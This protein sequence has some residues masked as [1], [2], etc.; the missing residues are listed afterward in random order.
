M[1]TPGL[2]WE[3]NQ[4]IRQISAVAFLFLFTA[5]SVLGSPIISIGTYYVSNTDTDYRIPIMVSTTS[6]ERVEGVNLA[7]QIADGGTPNGG[8]AT[9]PTIKDLDIVGTGTIFNASNTGCTPLYQGVGTENE[10]PY[11]LAMASTTVESGSLEANGIL[12]YLTI[13][14]SGAALGSY[15]LSLQE[16]G[17]N[18]DGGPWSTDFCGISAAIMDDGWIVVVPE[19]SVLMLLSVAIVVL[20]IGRRLR[21]SI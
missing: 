6:N 9:S 5:S 14:A 12:A 13:D 4:M 16:I 10:A 8:T 20:F 1:E 15:K 3:Y 21:N 18:L 19:P 11:L 2:F 17:E 7:V